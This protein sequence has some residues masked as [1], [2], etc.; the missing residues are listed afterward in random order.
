MGCLDKAAIVAKMTQ[1]LGSKAIW[2]QPIAALAREALN[3]QDA[4]KTKNTKDMKFKREKTPQIASKVII[5]RFLSSLPI[6]LLS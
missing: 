4:N 6:S 2:M 1:Y 5:V 3:A